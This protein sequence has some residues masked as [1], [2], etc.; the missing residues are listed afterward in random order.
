MQ[1]QGPWQPQTHISGAYTTFPNLQT[2]AS[3]RAY[4]LLQL[5]PEKEAYQEDRSGDLRHGPHPA[6]REKSLPVPR[7]TMP[8]LGQCNKTML[9]L[10][11]QQRSSDLIIKQYP[12]E[13]T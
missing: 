11:V 9:G 10:E 7:G 2:P 1:E 13:L 6:T 4:I 3:S 8:H 12:E 5:T